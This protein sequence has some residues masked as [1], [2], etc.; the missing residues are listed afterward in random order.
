MDNLNRYASHMTYDSKATLAF[1]EASKAYDAHLLTNHVVYPCDECKA[2][3]VEREWLAAECEDEYRCA[4]AEAK[5]HY[6]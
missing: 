2:L 1:V 6:S 4:I 5:E 3:L